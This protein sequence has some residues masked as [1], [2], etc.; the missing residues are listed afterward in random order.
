M[1]KILFIYNPNAG[2][3]L[4]KEH[5]ADV[6]NIISNA[7]YEMVVYPTKANKDAYEKVKNFT[8]DYARVICSGGDG[9]LDDVVTGMMARN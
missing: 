7:G 1:E 5:L 6:L 3:G 8:E 9:T 4:I 2:K